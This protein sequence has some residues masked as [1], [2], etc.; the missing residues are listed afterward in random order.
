MDVAADTKDQKTKLDLQKIFRLVN[1]EKTSCIEKTYFKFNIFLQALITKRS[2]GSDVCLDR[3]LFNVRN[4]SYKKG[5]S[6]K[7]V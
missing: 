3:K 2:V 4:K 7:S 5:N 6:D 1:D